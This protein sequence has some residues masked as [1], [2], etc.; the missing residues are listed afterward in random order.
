MSRYARNQLKRHQKK[1]QA[2]MREIFRDALIRTGLEDTLLFVHH[3]H[4][5]EKQNVRTENSG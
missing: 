2:D 4:T 1:Y 5:E 3:T